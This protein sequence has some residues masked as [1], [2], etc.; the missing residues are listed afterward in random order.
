MDPVAGHQ[1]DVEVWIDDDRVVRA[2]REIAHQC[3]LGMAAG[4]RDD[5][6]GRDLDVVN[7]ADQHLATIEVHVLVA[8]EGRIVVLFR[9]ARVVEVGDPGIAG[10]REDHHLV[11]GIGADGAERLPDGAMELE[12][13]LHVSS[14]RVH[15]QHD[16]PVASLHLE[17]LLEELLVLL[18]LGCRN[19]V[20]KRHLDF[21]FGG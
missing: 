15:A 1:A 2:D 21:S 8:V 17:V 4:P 5:A 7:Q 12:V 16:D 13:P 19:E 20:C 14:Q 3:Q 6:D 10:R 11:L 9:E 18:E